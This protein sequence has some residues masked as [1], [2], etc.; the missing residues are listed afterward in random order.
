VIMDS[1]VDPPGHGDQRTARL[2][3]SGRRPSIFAAAPRAATTSA[4]ACLLIARSVR[5]PVSSIGWNSGPA[6]PLQDPGPERRALAER[7]LALQEV[8]VARRQRRDAQ[9]RDAV[10]IGRACARPHLLAAHSVRAI[11]GSA[12]ALG[13]FAQMTSVTVGSFSKDSIGPNP[14]TSSETS[15]MMRLRS[16]CGSSAPR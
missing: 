9:V 5:F 13:Q 6:T 4:I 16:R 14:T 7:Q 3:S 15:L 10:P 2:R 12:R 11:L 1:G 8:V